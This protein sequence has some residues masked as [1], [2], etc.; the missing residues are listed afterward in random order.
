MKT[1]VGDRGVLISQGERQRLALARAILRRPDI[2]IL[3]EA[4]NSLDYDSEA[5]VLNAIN[6]LRGNMTVLMIAHRLSTIRW[7]DLI[8]VVEAGRI[9]ESGEWNELNARSGG[10]FRALCDAQRLVA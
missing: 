3:D 6:S 5:K 4:T 2:L 7:A 8:Y 10:R 1:I 9:V